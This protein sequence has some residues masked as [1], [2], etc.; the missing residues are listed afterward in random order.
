MVLGQAFVLSDPIEVRPIDK[1]YVR[2]LVPFATDLAFELGFH[3]PPRISDCLKDAT[4]SMTWKSVHLH[5][6]CDDAD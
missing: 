4:S 2:G 6:Y 3:A 1:I 5:G